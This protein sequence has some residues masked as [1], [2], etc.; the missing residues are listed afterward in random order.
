MILSS[1]PPGQPLAVWDAPAPRATASRGL[2]PAMT[3]TFVSMDSIEDVAGPSRR[4][5]ELTEQ[6]STHSVLSHTDNFRYPGRARDAADIQQNR[7]GRAPMTHSTIA[8]R[9][10]TFAAE[11]DVDTLPDA[12]RERAKAC[13]IHAMVVGIAGGAAD[14]GRHAEQTSDG[15]IEQPAA[16]GYARSLVTGHWHPAAA[17]AFINGVHLHARAQEDTHGTFHPGVSV[18]PAALAAAETGHV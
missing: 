4:G 1:G 7:S 9:L 14:F 18:I 3:G 15:S 5:S 2:L 13:L 12:V 11:L 16:G 10:A 17:A 6:S 8:E